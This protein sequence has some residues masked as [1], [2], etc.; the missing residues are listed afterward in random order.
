[1]ALYPIFLKLEGRKVLI[2]GGGKVA[3]EKIYAVLRSATDVTVV[4]PKVSQQIQAWADRGLLRHIPGEYQAGMAREYF[5]VIA[6][7]DSEK[8]N[9]DIYKEAQEAGVLCN[10]VDDPGFCDFYAPAVVSRGEFQIAIST[11]GKSPAL[12]Q[13]VR[14]KLEQEFG[15]E[16]ESWVGWLGRMREGIIRV[17]PRSRKRTEL[18]HLLAQSKPKSSGGPVIG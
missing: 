15:P 1:M 8:I 2:V 17:L 18:L 10:A 14:R 12:A 16:Y 9:R 6:C 7:T 11:G 13:H 5:L 3:E 4:A